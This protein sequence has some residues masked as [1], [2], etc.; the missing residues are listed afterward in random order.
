MLAIGSNELGPV[1]GEYYQCERCGRR[2]KIKYADRI[3]PDGTKEESKLLGYYKCGRKAY[4]CAI[5][6]R[7][8]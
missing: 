5:N 1:V 4:V 7:S 6:G 3:M 8:I 2:H